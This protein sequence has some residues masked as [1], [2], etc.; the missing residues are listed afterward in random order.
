MFSAN[1][2]DIQNEKLDKLCIISLI[3][4][5]ESFKMLSFHFL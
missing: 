5:H 2:L 1:F 3:Q 4:Q